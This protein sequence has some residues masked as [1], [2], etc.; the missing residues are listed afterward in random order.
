MRVTRSDVRLSRAEFSE[1]R[2]VMSGRT[3][4]DRA[5]DRRAF[6]KALE[7]FVAR[8]R[9]DACREGFTDA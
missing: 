1:I 6:V 7:D 8:K 2:D 4:D 5:R 9:A 3:D